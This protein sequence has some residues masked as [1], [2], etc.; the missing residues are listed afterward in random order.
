[1]NKDNK[2]CD[3]DYLTPR[4]VADIMM[5]TP[6][7]VRQWAQKGIIKALTTPGGHRRFLRKDV[8]AL[9]NAQQVTTNIPQPRIMIVDDDEQFLEL[10]KELLES[11]PLPA[12][13]ETAQD[14]FDA[15]SKVR[16]FKPDTVLLDLNMPGL[17]GYSVCEKIKADPATASIRVIAITG[18][19]SIEN[20]R[21]ILSLGAEKC[22]QKPLDEDELLQVLGLAK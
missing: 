5:V 14:G 10:Y 17:D 16:F 19:A 13:V 1:M 20:V 12:T 6:V 11:A 7:T 2:K 21:R 8:E 3:I 22:L 18:N 9:A 15:G 4:E